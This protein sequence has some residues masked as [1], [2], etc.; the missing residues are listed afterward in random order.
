MNERCP[1][2]AWLQARILVVLTA[3]AVPA[4]TC[5]M[6]WPQEVVAEE[7]TIVVY[8]PQPESLTGNTLTG[9]AAMSLELKGSDEPIFGAFWFE[10][11]I[12]TDMDAG[13]ALIRDLKVSKVRWPDS[14][15]AGEQRFTAIVESA[16]PENGFEISMEQLIGEP[17]DRGHRATEPPGAEK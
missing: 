7:G 6:D 8:Q 17:R 5:A 2:H 9:R 3:L 15:D 12:T 10:A 13:T 11:R 14:K 4:I 16:I 1:S